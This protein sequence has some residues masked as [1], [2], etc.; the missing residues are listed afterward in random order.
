MF[1]LSTVALLGAEAVGSNVDCPAQDEASLLQMPVVQNTLDAT[2]SECRCPGYYQEECE[3]EAA[4][5]CI[6]SSAGTSNSPW[7]QCDE[8]VVPPPFVPGPIVEPLPPVVAPLQFDQSGTNN[9]C[10]TSNND[11]YTQTS[12]SRSGW[13]LDTSSNGGWRWCGITADEC[14]T[15]CTGL[16]D[17]QEIY[18]TPNSC[19]FPSRAVCNTGSHAPGGAGGMRYIV[20]PEVEVVPFP[21]DVVPEPEPEDLP[22]LANHGA[23]CWNPCGQTAGACE[24]CGT[25]GFCCREGFAGD[26]EECGGRGAPNFHTCILPDEEPEEP[27]EL[28]PLQNEGENCWNP[29]D[30]TAGACEYCGTE[31]LCCREGF[32]SDPAECGG[33]GASNFHTCILPEDEPEETALQNQGENCWNPCDQTAGS[34]DYCGTEGLCCREGFGSDPAECGGRGAPNFHTCVLPVVPTI[35]QNQGANCWNPCDQTA[36]PCDFCGTEGVCCRQG[37]ASD[38]EECG[39]LGAPNFHTCILPVEMEEEPQYPDTE[40]PEQTEWTLIAHHVLSGGLF[41]D[42]TRNTFIENA[43]DPTASTYMIAGQV[44]PSDYLVDGKYQLR[45]EYNDLDDAHLP[46]NDGPPLSGS[47]TLE[48]LQS[49]WVTA[50]TVTGFEAISPSDLSTSA[51]GAGCQFSGLARSSNENTVLDGSH[52]HGYWFGSVGA[53]AT[54][55]GGIPAWKGGVAQS[56]SLYVRR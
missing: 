23:N 13:N 17:C 19:C 27:E 40:I 26:P 38:P 37:F 47:V 52:Q 9:W 3:A 51:G 7:C 44:T 33:R 56:L 5:G 30:Q 12:S 55:S 24:Y 16:G 11:F 46:C 49:S 31:G 48:W 43:G 25:E 34:C 50:E 42:A 14:Q 36:G 45:L 2:D 4:Q 28:A 15:E 54:W 35:L 39:G 29:C 1:R 21:P 8:S 41:A 10:G 6:W 18:W 53:V 20:V 22:E 32:G